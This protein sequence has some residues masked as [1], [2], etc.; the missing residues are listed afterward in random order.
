VY[1][2]QLLREI[3]AK[4]REKYKVKIN[5]IPYRFVGAAICT[6]AFATTAF[7]QLQFTAISATAEQ[8]IQLTWASISN[9]T[10]E[11]DEADTLETNAQGTITWNQL[12]TQYPSQGSNTFWL[13]TGNYVDVPAIVHPKYSTARFYRVVDLGPDTTSD[14]PSVTILSPTNGFVASGNVT[15]TVSASTDQATLS[16]ALYVDGQEMNA[17]DTTTNNVQNGTNFVTDTYLINTCEWFNGPHILFATAACASGLTGPVN[18]SPIYTGNTVSAFVP[19]TF[20]NLITELAFSQVFFD[21]TQGQTQQVT[22]VFASNVNWTLAVQDINTNTVYTNSG[23]GTSMLVNWDGNGNGETTLPAGVYT[24]L[25]S[26]QT[27]GQSGSGGGGGSGGGSGGGPPEMD[28]S[29]SRTPSASGGEVLEVPLPP[30]P[31]GMSYGVDK[32]GNEITTTTIEIPATSGTVNASATSS[33]GR[34]SPDGV[35]GDDSPAPGEQ[36]TRGPVRPPTA[37]VR[38]TVG[39]IGVA[40]QTYT[41]NGPA[42]YLLNDPPNCLI[43]GPIVIQN[44]PTDRRVQFT[45]IPQHG[46]QAKNFVTAMKKGGWNASFVTADNQVQVSTITGSASPFN[47]VNLGMLL[48]HGCYGTSADDCYNGCE[49]MYFPIGNV[50]GGATWV[51]MGAMDFGGTATNGLEWMLIDTCFSLYQHNWN[52]MQS[53]NV[54]PYN[55]NLHFLLG[56]DSESFANVEIEELWAKYMLFGKP[57]GGPMTIQAAWYQAGQDAYQATHLNYGGSVIYATAGDANCSGD[58]LLTN[59]PP[60]GTQFYDSKQVYPVP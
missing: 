5:S 15:I 21:P 22:A 17:A 12:C 47:Q 4:E 57:P 13:D 38:G 23:S 30:A 45:P 54:K 37:P 60:T 2:F 32:N 41:E 14:E 50:Y 59:S 52:S 31:P 10:Y 24:Y 58:Y 18:G 11:I 48:L 49:Q 51:P 29:I 1:A 20:N 9:E 33:G 53:A 8:A 26:A 27:N 28:S 44:F 40:Y 3:P 42:G 16:T 25:V 36:S 46:P 34:F 55:S 56:S 43:E 39:T 35:S 7:S 19:V 6:L